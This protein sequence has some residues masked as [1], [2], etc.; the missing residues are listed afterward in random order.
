MAKRKRKNNDLLNTT[1]ID[2]I[3]NTKPTK[4]HGWRSVTCV[5]YL[6]FT[7]IWQ[8]YHSIKLRVKYF[9]NMIH[10]QTKQWIPPPFPIS[11]ITLSICYLNIFLLFCIYFRYHK[12]F[13]F[14]GAEW[15]RQLDYLTI[16]TSLS[17]IRRG[18]VNYRKG[19]LDS[20]PQVK[21]L[22][23]CFPMVGG[24]LRIVRLL[25]PLKLVAMI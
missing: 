24:S 20:H 5:Q 2:K 19:A 25:P 15:L 13:M 21:K 4:N 3:S 22:T 1:H 18:F 6:W 16:R 10:G 9:R 23:S 11:S 17:P 7:N 8:I 12:C 14:K